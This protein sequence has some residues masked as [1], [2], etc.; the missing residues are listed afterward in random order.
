MAGGR[1]VAAHE[2]APGDPLA[3][4]SDGQVRTLARAAL[5]AGL[6]TGS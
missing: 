1:L 3:G 4:L 6:E 2:A 5:A